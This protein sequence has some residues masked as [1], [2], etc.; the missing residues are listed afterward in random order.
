MESHRHHSDP[1]MVICLGTVM[2][3]ISLKYLMLFKKI[4]FVFVLDKPAVSRTAKHLRKT[5]RRRQSDCLKD[6]VQ[7]GFDIFSSSEF[8]YTVH[9]LKQTEPFV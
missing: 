5:V 8:A 2:F 3:S 4:Q 6:L 7:F 9:F 1:E